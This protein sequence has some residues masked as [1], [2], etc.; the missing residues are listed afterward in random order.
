VGVGRGGGGGGG[1][2]GKR[3]GARRARKGARRQP[4]GGGGC[5]A[6]GSAAAAARRRDGPMG[7]AASDHAAGSDGRGSWRRRDRGCVQRASRGGGGEDPE[8][9]RARRGSEL[10]GDRGIVRCR[11]SR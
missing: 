5:P 4:R 11:A 3:A 8:L 1:G 2:G 9:R 7:A 10:D 6:T